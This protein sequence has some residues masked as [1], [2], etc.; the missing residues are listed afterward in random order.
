MK[1]IVTTGNLYIDI[2]G[3]AC[4]LAYKELQAKKGIDSEVVFL[5][6]P[7]STVPKTVKSWGLNYK[8]S[9]PKNNDNLNFV[10][11]DCANPKLM[12]SFVNLSKVVKVYDHHIFGEEKLW[13]NYKADVIIEPVG[14]CA[15]L[16]WEEFKSS[17]LNGKIS[18][19]SANLLYTAIFSNTLNFNASVTTER[20][21]LAAKELLRYTKLPGNWIRKYYEESE[22]Q[23][24]CDPK[25]AVEND[26]KVVD[27]PEKNI[28]ITIGQIEMWNS[29]D[30]ILNNQNTIK[31]ALVSFGIDKWFL[32][33]PSISESKNYIYTENNELKS[34]LAK[35]INADFDGNLGTTPKLWL[36]KEILKKIIK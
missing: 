13:E 27:F 4:A 29:K 22:Q 12:P 3:M 31:D 1:T 8:S 35:T 24:F 25:L 2:D 20:D 7:N 19:V 36:R 17:N 23:T 9:V 18:N 16:I 11:V 32:T 15:T 33:A 34:L 14:S 21:V 5:S 26:T 10:I 30:F 28:K 6:E